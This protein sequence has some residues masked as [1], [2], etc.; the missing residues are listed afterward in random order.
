MEKKPGEVLTSVKVRPRLAH[1]GS[2]IYLCINKKWQKTYNLKYG[3]N[4]Q[5]LESKLW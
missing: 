3:A 2:S 5:L 1:V 4:A